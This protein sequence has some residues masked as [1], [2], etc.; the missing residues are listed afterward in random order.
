MKLKLY[1]L[2]SFLLVV[3]AVFPIESV[4]D[5]TD[6]DRVSQQ[7]IGAIFRRDQY[8]LRKLVI[9]TVKIP[10]IREDTPITRIQGL[11][12]SKKDTKVFI[13]YFGE[14]K[15]EDHDEGIRRI[16]FIWEVTVTRDK[17][18]NIT[19]VSDAANPFM[20]ELRATKTY[21]SKNNKTVLVPSYFPNDVTHVKSHTN[22]DKISIEYKSH[23]SIL[24]LK[25]SPF[26]TQNLNPINQGFVQ[27]KVKDGE[28]TYIKKLSDGF[29][30]N[31]VD[32]G[33]QYSV[34]FKIHKHSASNK[35]KSE[36]IQ[37]VN[38]MFR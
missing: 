2:L 4:A 30:I 33:L 15:I 22:E 12:S 27:V 25:A 13:G 29:Q 35:A 31:F 26:N 17:V 14:E 18:T 1:L 21:K 34:S 36:L 11:P 28:E 20:N 3:T 9:P 16:A 24:T 32:D 38:S 7:F 37:V 8:K 23:E 6:T 19:V 5:E 10:E